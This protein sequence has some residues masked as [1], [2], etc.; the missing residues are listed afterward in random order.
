MLQ[1][2]LAVVPAANLEPHPRGSDAGIVE[3]FR[4]VTLSLGCVHQCCPLWHR[5]GDSGGVARL[6]GT[7]ALSPQAW[8]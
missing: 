3:W 4:D 2:S 7:A 1:I 5:Y 6:R 8:P